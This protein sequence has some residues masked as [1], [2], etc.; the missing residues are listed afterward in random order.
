MKRLISIILSAILFVVACADGNGAKS[1]GAGSFSEMKIK[2]D[3]KSESGKHTLTATLND[4]SSSRALAEILRKGGVSIEMH[5]Y[6]NFE[7]VGPLPAPLP[8]NDAR[9]TTEPGDIIL[10][11]GNQITIYYDANSWNFTR[12]G[13]IDGV[14][15]A[16]LKGILGG[17]N[18]KAEFSLAE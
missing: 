13:R 17:G 5:D 8:R 7:K 14:S 4:N 3:I 16:E 2:I 18:V 10:Y 1:S 15:Q 6:G 11:Q 9:I 12:L